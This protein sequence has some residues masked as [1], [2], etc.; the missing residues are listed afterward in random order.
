MAVSC[1]FRVSHVSVRR[2][3]NPNRLSRAFVSS[4]HC[5]QLISA[6]RL[7]TLGACFSFAVGLMCVIGVGGISAAEV[8][9][10]L[11]F[12]VSLT[13]QFGMVTRQTAEVENNSE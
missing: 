7:D 5:T 10:V 8:G 2:L 3:A 9:L 11:S 1:R 6:I 12:C 4:V 13:Q